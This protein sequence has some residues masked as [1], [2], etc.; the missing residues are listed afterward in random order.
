MSIHQKQFQPLQQFK[1]HG[2][3]RIKGS[4]CSAAGFPQWRGI[5]SRARRIDTQ[6]RFIR[7][8]NKEERIIAKTGFKILDS[9]MHV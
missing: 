6:S 1:S 3:A 9:D 7:P 8:L 5:E 2:R 4:R